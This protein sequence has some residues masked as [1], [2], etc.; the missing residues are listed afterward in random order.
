M[1][2]K[3]LVAVGLLFVSL[4]YPTSAAT[5]NVIGTYNNWPTTW[6]PI[7]GLSDPNDGLTRYWLDFVGDNTDHVGYWVARPDY[8]FFRVRIRGDATP[9]S[10]NDS[11]FVLIDVVGDSQEYVPQY[12]FVWDSKETQV[13]NHGLEMVRLGT[14]GPTWG[15]TTMDDVDGSSGQKLS[16]DINGGGRT[17]DGYVRLITGISTANLGTTMF[18]DFAVSWQYLT[19]YT[20]L[21][22]TQQWRVTFAS[23]DNANDHNQ[24]RYD[25]AGGA[26][27]NS[28]LSAGWSGI[29]TVPEP[30]ALAQALLAAVVL[31]PT[32]VWSRNRRKH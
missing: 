9:S 27:P 16:N 17:T 7:P 12:G 22:P 6:Y 32:L 28:S 26:N 29:I 20:A 23:I 3:I 10:Y 21:S 24:L 13:A 5:Y 30:P 8:V 4:V 31:G 15:Q 18:L 14:L 1:K 11:T 19:N 2:H 25:I